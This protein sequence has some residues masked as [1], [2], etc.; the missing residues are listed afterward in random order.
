MLI[1]TAMELMG[2]T[3][4]QTVAPT[5][6]TC[7]ELRTLL[8]I[9]MVQVKQDPLR[10]HAHLLEQHHLDTQG[11]TRD[12]QAHKRAHH[13]GLSLRQWITQTKPRSAY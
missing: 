8:R 11:C 10:A 13:R 7:V 5:E 2:V 1:T 9:A 12:K 3:A 4:D 6:W